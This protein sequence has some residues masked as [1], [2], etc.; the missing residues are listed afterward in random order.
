MEEQRRFAAAKIVEEYESFAE[1]CRAF[2]ISRKT[3][4]KSWARSEEG[5]LEVLYDRSHRVRSHPFMTDPVMVAREATVATAHQ[6]RHTRGVTDEADVEQAWI[7]EV[8]KRARELET[9]QVRGLTWVE[10]RRVMLGT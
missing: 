9:G 7:D 5:G 3:G 8:H 4:Y 10:A 6:I 1:L 2:G